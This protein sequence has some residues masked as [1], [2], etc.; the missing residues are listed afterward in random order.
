MASWAETM[1]QL[2]AEYVREARA[3]LETV[4]L[5]VERLEQDRSPKALPDL[6][7]RFHGLAGSGFTYGFP[8]VSALGRRGEKAC[9]TV[10]ERGGAPLPTELGEWHAVLHGLRREFGFGSREDGAGRERASRSSERPRVLV[11]DDDATVRAI[12]APL[13]ESDGM[14]VLTAGSR[15]EAFRHL[16]GGLPDAM[17]VDILLPDGLGYTLVEHVRALSGG[18]TTPVLMIS[19]LHELDDRVD[20]IHCGADGFFDKPVAWEAL[21]ARLRQLL[22]RG[23]PRPARVLVVADQTGPASLLERMLAAAGYDIRVCLEPAQVHSSVATFDPD[24]VLADTP[25]FASGTGEPVSRLHRLGGEELPVLLLTESAPPPLLDG[26]ADRT[27]VLVKPVPAERL[28]SIVAAHLERGR[29]LRRLREQDGLTGLLNHTA[30]QERA[31]AH[32]AGPAPRAACVLIDVDGL[33]AVNEAHGHRAGD[34]VLSDLASL[35][36]K[37]L[38]HTDVIGRTG[39]QQFAVLLDGLSEAEATRLAERLRAEFSS[40][41]HT[42]PHGAAFPVSFSV[43][44]AALDGVPGSV[45]ELAQAAAGAL[46]AARAG[47]RERV[48]SSSGMAPAPL[49]E[50]L[51]VAS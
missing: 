20:A 21:R 42:P 4:T 7:R 48:V 36:R 18:E 6:A 34:R 43:G 12:L 26:A 37:R 50:A 2:R 46:R 47:R 14:S 19:V 32:L 38:R 27:E 17:V 3:N 1:Q 44:V 25:R 24:L 49:A 11:V 51:A 28:L 13:L 41:D 33:A 40:R 39:G 10:A 29:L 15:A 31:R 35:L 9:K 16:E 8:E 5:L 22:A 45:E 23:R 30:F